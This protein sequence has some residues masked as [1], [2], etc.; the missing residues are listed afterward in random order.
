MPAHGTVTF[1]YPWFWKNHPNGCP[2]SSFITLL[3]NQSSVLNL[4]NILNLLNL[5]DYNFPE[6]LV[7]PIGWTREHMVRQFWCFPM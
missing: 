6:S 5:N 7:L 4:K 3:L 2:G 1:S